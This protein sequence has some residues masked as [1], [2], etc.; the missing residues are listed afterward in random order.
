[1]CDKIRRGE[2]D[3]LVADPTVTKYRRLQFVDR[4]I[5]LKAPLPLLDRRR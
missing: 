4:D 1:M 3:E 2:L 5:V